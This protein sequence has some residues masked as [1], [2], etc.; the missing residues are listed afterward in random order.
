MEVLCVSPGDRSRYIAPAHR[1]LLSP[2][3]RVRLSAVTLLA[4]IGSPKDTAPTVALL[5]DE[6][7]LVVIEASKTLASVGGPND[8]I[9][10][11]AYLRSAAARGLNPEFLKGVAKRRD[12]LRDRLSR[13]T[14]VPTKE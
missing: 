10:L 11:D 7:D 13:P 8:L 1:A 2:D 3:H 5:F 9:A 12:I 4:H 6:S 14:V